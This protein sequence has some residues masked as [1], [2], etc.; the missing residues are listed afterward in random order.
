M[1]L[2]TSRILY[3]SYEYYLCLLTK[4]KRETCVCSFIISGAVF[5][6]I[7]VIHCDIKL[8]STIIYFIIKAVYNSQYNSPTD[9]RNLPRQHRK[10]AI[11]TPFF[12]SYPTGHIESGTV[13]G[14]PR[15]LFRW[16]SFPRWS[17]HSLSFRPWNTHRGQV[18][19]NLQ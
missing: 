16:S 1:Y 11:S 7:C 14:Y 19:R 2:F 6:F 18:K 9:D 17:F 4:L 10:W 5:Y 3:W 13:R 15:A 12:N 8:A